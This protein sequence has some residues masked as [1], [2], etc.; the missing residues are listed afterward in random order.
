[1]SHYIRLTEFIA[2]N[3]SDA[4]RLDELVRGGQ[5]TLRRSAGFLRCETFRDADD[6]R[7]VVSMEVWESP[8]D[9]AA[10]AS[11]I[12]G[13]LVQDAM[14]LMSG[15]PASRD[16]A[17]TIDLT[18]SPND[19][20]LRLVVVVG[21][22][23]QG[24]MGRVVADWILSHL[25]ASSDF[26]TKVID[27]VDIALPDAL[28]E[29]PADLGDPDKRTS[30]LNRT[31]GLLAAADAVLLVTPEYNHAMPASLKHFIDWHFSEWRGKPIACVG[32]G[33]MSG[34]SNAVESLRLVLA[35]LH[36]VV[37]RDAVLLNA[38]WEIFG[39]DGRLVDPQATEAAAETML[40]QLVWWGEAL[41][42]G[43]QTRA[44]K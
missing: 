11:D 40:S 34:G 38:P 3:P 36:A 24:R 23:R 33:G 9:R 35:E 22:V 6:A 43:R 10:G 17:G 20:P 7:K 42:Q 5:D 16:L 14:K 25:D 19:A 26:S 29:N 15:P 18:A 41:R 1:M 2:E 12:P 37:I 39:E 30:D 28:P 31:S 27:L 4:P 8:A 44:Y 21:S 32:Y 13:D